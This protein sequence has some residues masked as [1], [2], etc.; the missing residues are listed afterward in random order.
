VAIPLFRWISRWRESADFHVGLDSLIA[1]ARPDAA[2]GDRL[3]W[4]RDLAAWLLAGS[5]GTPEAGERSPQAVRLQHLLGLL[6]RQPD[7]KAAFAAM[8]RAALEQRDAFDLLIETGMPRESGFVAEFLGR[9]LARVLPEPPATDLAGLFLQVFPRRAHAEIVQGISDENWSGIQSLLAHGDAP[10]GVQAQLGEAA[11]RAVESL[12]TQACAATLPSAVR[13]RMQVTEGQSLAAWDLPAAATAFSRA[14]LTGYLAERELAADALRRVVERSLV[15]IE[16]AY[17]H[18][19]LQGV[20]IAIVY[21]LERIRA[22]LKRIGELTDLLAAPESAAR[23]LPHFVAHLIRDVHDHRSAIA[24]LSQ[25]FEL[26][27]RKV[28]ERS[29]ETGEHYITR[30]RAEYADMVKRASGGGAVLAVTTYVKFAFAALHWPPFFDGL[31]ASVNYAASFVFIQFAG[32]TVATKQ[33]AM[34]APALAARM[35][36]LANPQRMEAFVD[37]VVNL[38][39]SQ[40][41]SIFGNVFVVF[42]VAYGLGLLLA[43]ANMIPAD[44]DKAAKTIGSLSIWGPSALFAAFTGVLLWF[45]SVLAGWVD[46]WFHYR[47][48]GPAIAGHR[49]LAYVFGPSAMQRAARFL[50]HEIAGL[51]AN[52]SLG[53]LLGSMPVLLAFFGLPVEVRHVTLSS[54]QLA[55]SVVVLG[56]SVLSTGAFWLAVAGIVLI[57][58]LNVGVSFALALQVA[59]GARESSGASRGAIYRAIRRRMLREPASFLFPKD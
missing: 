37:D 44:A 23:M 16:Q 3:A 14:C 34:T 26:A 11:A 55:A 57:G 52:I 59:I 46:N 29:A 25:N 38:V 53:F 40:S 21:Q 20:S 12:A 24:L 39:R 35:K 9:L 6:E 41:A 36:D 1:R 7:A 17:T 15:E 2:V 28:V 56:G 54:G 50:D 32:L 13:R 10:G 5:A 8:L 30:D 49:R 47:R 48:L 4:L 18:L 58:V 31:L 45:S 42:P 43:G 19:D 33:P 22:Q 27:A 51:T